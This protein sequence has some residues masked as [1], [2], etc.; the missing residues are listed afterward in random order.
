MF[1]RYFLG[2][3]VK[4]KIYEFSDCEQAEFSYSRLLGERLKVSRQ[5]F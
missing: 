2:F 5:L 4:T 1:T 3:P